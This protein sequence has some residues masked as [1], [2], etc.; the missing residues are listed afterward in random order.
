M[1]LSLVINEMVDEKVHLANEGMV[2]K[3]NFEKTYD[4]VDCDL[5]NPALLGKGHMESNCTSDGFFFAVKEVSLL[6]QGSQGKQSI[7]QLEQEISLLSQFEHENIVRYYGTDKFF[8]FLIDSLPASTVSENETAN[9][10]RTYLSFNPIH[11]IQSD[12]TM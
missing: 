12:L 10:K 7:Y 9:G 5:P 2:F 3:I 8:R 6:D 1:D 11:K 4:Q